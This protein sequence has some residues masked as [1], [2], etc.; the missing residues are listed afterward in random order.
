MAKD[1]SDN[2]V[3]GKPSDDSEKTRSAGSADAEAPMNE[4]TQS[5]DADVTAKTNG[6]IKNHVIAAMGLGL[7][8][9]PVVDMVSIVAVQMNMVRKLG[10]AHDVPF[11]ENAVRGSILAL[12]GGVLPVSLGLTAASFIKLVPGLGSVTGAAGVVVLA[13]A[14][15]Y[16][17]GAV[18]E[19]H[20]ASGGTF[21]N[22]DISKA[23][24]L[25]RRKVE[26]GKGVAKDLGDE[27]AD[28]KAAA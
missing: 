6:I 4:E 3:Y 13:G 26:E 7:V 17:V 22:F 12:V 16:A 18:F 20:L 28:A 21:L 23:R 24:D 8:P 10:A 2:S 15:T 25:F 11:K 19:R 27:A 5:S 9:L 14:V 1:G